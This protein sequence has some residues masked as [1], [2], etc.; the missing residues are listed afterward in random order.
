MSARTLTIL[1]L[2]SLTW[3]LFAGAPAAAQQS[4]T[5]T[6]TVTDT[7]GETLPGANIRLV[8][9]Q[10]GTSTG[11]DG[12]YRISEIEPGTYMV[13]VSF[14][15]YETVEQEA[16]FQSGSSRRLCGERA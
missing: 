10:K 13:R 4:A 3:L 12:S 8:G 9:T 7:D 14:V 16:T 11:S 1:F 2:G 6:G 5:L 15:G